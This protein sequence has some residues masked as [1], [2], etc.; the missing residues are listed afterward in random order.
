MPT[1]FAASE[2]I[3]K[4]GNDTIEGVR[5]IEY[6]HQQMRSNIYALGT[7]ERIGMVSGAQSIEGRLRVASTSD[8]LNQMAGEF[9]VI[10]ILKH[11]AIQMTVTFDEC[12][13]LEKNFSI[14][15]NGHGEVVY[16]F[17]AARMREEVGAAQQ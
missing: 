1:L 7:T 2:S 4:V 3:V 5:A 13:M 16:T 17:S 9:Q 10:A 15:V 12:Y 14:E 8:V 11:G 6:R